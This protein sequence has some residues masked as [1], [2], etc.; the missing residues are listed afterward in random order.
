MAVVTPEMDEWRAY[1]LDENELP[2]V[3]NKQA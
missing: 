3:A 1:R 2:P